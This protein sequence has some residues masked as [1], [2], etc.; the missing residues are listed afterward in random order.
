MKL[1]FQ[2]F[3]DEIDA[4]IEFLTSEAWEFHGNPNPKPEGI[5][6]NYEN[7]IYASDDCKTFWVI[8]DQ[9]TKVGYVRIYDL[10]NGTP[11]FDIRI[12]SKYKGMGI[13][14]STVNWLTKYI[15][16]NYLDKDRLEGYTRQDNYPMRSVFHKCGFVK[17]AH[18]RKAWPGKDGKLYDAIG[19][20]ITKA[21]WENGQVTLVLWEDFKY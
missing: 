20:G 3:K 2:E 13:G 8:L 5:R 6:K 17:E 19:Y 10:E 14:T 12:L 4:L 9:D 21:D 18:H 16:E 11:L 15:F 1:H 7:H